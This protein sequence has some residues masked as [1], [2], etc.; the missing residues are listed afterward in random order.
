MSDVR[1]LLSAVLLAM[2][3][4]A[5]VSAGFIRYVDEDGPRIVTVRLAELAADHVLQASAS[6]RS[7]DGA[8]GTALVSP[9]Y[10]AERTR[11]WAASLEKAL[12]A[13]AARN[14]AVLLPARAVAA[15]AVDV[16]R[17]VIF[18]MELIFQVLDAAAEQEARP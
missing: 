16:T 11:A 6:A 12:D 9:E 2:G 3:V 1:V 15:G 5:A 18:E 7:M 4:S 8:G 17:E 13:V 14:G 10:D